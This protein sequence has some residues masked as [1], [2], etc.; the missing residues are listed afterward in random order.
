MKFS[1]CEH[2]ICF[3]MWNHSCILIFPLN[4]IQTRWFFIY[5]GG[6]INCLSGFC[7]TFLRKV[8]VLIRKIHHKI[9]VLQQKKENWKNARNVFCT[10]TWFLSHFSLLKLMKNESNHDT[11][12]WQKNFCSESLQL[13]IYR[14]GQPNREYTMWKFSDFSAP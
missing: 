8:F 2:C 13:S 9:K 4:F 3:M 1:H 5:F 11:F 10:K 6:K 7:L 12:F 14:P